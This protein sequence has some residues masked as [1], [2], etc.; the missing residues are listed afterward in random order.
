MRIPD[1]KRIRRSKYFL[2]T[3]L[4]LL[5]KVEGAKGCTEET[6]SALHSAAVEIQQVSKRLDEIVENENQ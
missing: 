3:S 6:S 4:V 2:D 1:I 5:A